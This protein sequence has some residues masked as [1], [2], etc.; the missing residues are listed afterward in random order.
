MLWLNKKVQFQF[1]G[2][3]LLA[4]ND[5]TKLS[6]VVKSKVAYRPKEKE[7]G[8]TW[9]KQLCQSRLDNVFVSRYLSNK[10]TKV[11]VVWAIEQ[12]DHASVAV[13]MYLKEEIK[14]MDYPLAFK[15]W[16]H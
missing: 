12:S 8:Y 7:G 11:E 1:S 10:I 15:N 3:V 2:S 9:N 14:G 4:Q 16:R 6:K 13:V 5:G